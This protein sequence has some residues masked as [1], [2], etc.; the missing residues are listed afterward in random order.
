MLREDWRQMTAERGTAILLRGSEEDRIGCWR[1]Y[2]AAHLYR[3]EC[4]MF[5]L[6]LLSGIYV[7][8]QTKDPKATQ[9]RLNQ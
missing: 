7:I 5:D 2:I 9:R 3:P 1:I 6:L 4:R 8:E